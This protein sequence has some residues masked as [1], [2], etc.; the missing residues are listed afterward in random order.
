MKA[1]ISQ[2]PKHRRNLFELDNA[3]NLSRGELVHTFVPTI[4]FWKLLSAKHH[5]IL[6]SRGS[7]KTAMGRML[8][9]DHLSAWRGEERVLKIIHE[10]SFVGMFMPTGLEWVGGLRNK[11]WQN[12]DEQEQLFQWR[13]NLN[14]CAAMVT[15]LQSCIDTYS[16]TPAERVRL[17]R[18]LSKRLST[19]WFGSD[20][21]RT[22]LGEVVMFLE[23]L[24]YTKQQQLAWQRVSGEAHATPVIGGQFHT[25]LLVPLRRGIAHAERL[26]LV[27]TSTT[28]LLCVDEAELLDPIHHRVLNTV[29]RADSDGVFLKTATMPF[30]HYTLETNSAVP[31]NEGHDFEYVYIDQD[32][33]N[34][35]HHASKEMSF[36]RAVFSARFRESQL[37]ESSPQS[38]SLS[39]L[40]GSSSLLDRYETDWDADSSRMWRLLEKYGDQ[41]TIERAH[42]LKGTKQF[43]ASVARKIQPAL[44]LREE[45]DVA[46]GNKKPALYS[47]ASLI[48]RCADGNP[49]RLVRMINAILTENWPDAKKGRIPEASQTQSMKRFSKA[50]LNRLESEPNVG[51]RLHKLVQSVGVFMSEYLYGQGVSTDQLS[52]ISVPSDMDLETRELIRIAVGIGVLF[53]HAP[54]GEAEFIPADTGD[55]RF[56]YGLAPHFGLI[57]RHGKKRSLRSILGSDARPAGQLGLTFAEGTDE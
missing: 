19:D 28:W 57:P 23:D 18:A 41:T 48:V 56:A 16:R 37:A 13:F 47:G 11:P 35:P 51:P 1:R 53:P 10:R 15:A 27:D 43:S 54:R 17:E 50:M 46:V 39:K 52:S 20:E 45:R 5:V 36:A 12:E 9:H 4:R 44:L 40:L 8:A 42:R 31:L 29:M 21:P 30:G 2:R 26:S 7:G 24:D 25:D 14:S 6:G 49:R 38:G 55:F 32:A 3:R 22:S 33:G 34:L